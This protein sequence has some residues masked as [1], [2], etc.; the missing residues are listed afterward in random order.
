MSCV[1]DGRLRL[2]VAASATAP[3]L[4]KHGSRRSVILPI[5]KVTFNIFQI[6]S[7]YL[8]RK[9]RSQDKK[10][11]TQVIT[12]VNSPRLRLGQLSTVGLDMRADMET[13]D[14]L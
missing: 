3:A 5:S 12:K 13:Y 7:A 1:S 2:V 8:F 4:C 14:N 11:I 6:I 9:V 10:V